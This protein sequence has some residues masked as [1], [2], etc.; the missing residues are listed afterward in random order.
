MNSKFGLCSGKNEK[1][2]TLKMYVVI[3][4]TQNNRAKIMKQGLGL[5]MTY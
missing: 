3:G 1:Q 4:W 2:T 5:S